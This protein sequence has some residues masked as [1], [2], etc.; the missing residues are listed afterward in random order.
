MRLPPGGLVRRR[1]AIGQPCAACGMRHAAV[2]LPPG[3]LA[4]HTAA[5]GQFRTQGGERRRIRSPFFVAS[6]RIGGRAEGL[7]SSKSITAIRQT[8]ILLD[9]WKFEASGERREKFRERLLKRRFPMFKTPYLS[10]K[11]CNANCSSCV[12]VL[13]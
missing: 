2:R 5:I 9:K 4:R 13:R 6:G 12:D 8:E 1:A 3:S 11:T 10:G 7:F